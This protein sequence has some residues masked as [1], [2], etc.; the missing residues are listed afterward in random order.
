MD[1]EHCPPSETEVED[2]SEYRESLAD[3][4][5]GYGPYVAVE[6]LA[7]WVARGKRM[8]VGEREAEKARLAAR[9]EAEDKAA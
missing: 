4:E 7:E 8:I 5:D 3:D 9:S 2:A 6:A 1:H